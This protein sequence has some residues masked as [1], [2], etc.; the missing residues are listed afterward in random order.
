MDAQKELLE[1]M[2]VPEHVLR[3][4][5]RMRVLTEVDV[6]GPVAHALACMMTRMPFP[7]CVL[8]GE[9]WDS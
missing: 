1:L 9:E 5:L 3:P 8:I 7:G 4:R 2:A 6:L